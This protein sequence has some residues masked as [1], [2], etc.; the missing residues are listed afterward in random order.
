MLASAIDVPFDTLRYSG[1]NKPQ[2]GGNTR[3]QGNALGSGGIATQALKGRN[4]MPTAFYVPP[5]Q[6][7]KSVRRSH[8]QG[9]A[10]G[11]RIA[12]LSGLEGGTPSRVHRELSRF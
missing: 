4:P 8:S 6:G 5:F 3:A 9:V 10:L 12:A 2:R 1:G 11:F 7:S